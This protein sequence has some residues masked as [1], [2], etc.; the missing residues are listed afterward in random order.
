MTASN[1]TPT[2]II[3]EDPSAAPAN[4]VIIRQ[5]APSSYVIEETGAKVQISDNSLLTVETDMGESAPKATAQTERYRF[6]SA[7]G[8]VELTVADGSLA[9]KFLS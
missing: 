5:S 9:A 3:T 7:H 1:Q 6:L 2:I 4:A 8:W